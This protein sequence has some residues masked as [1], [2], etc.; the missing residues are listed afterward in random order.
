MTPISPEHLKL[1]GSGPIVLI[2]KIIIALESDDDVKSIV[3]EMNGV[4]ALKTFELLL[5]STFGEPPV[6]MGDFGEDLQAMTKRIFLRASID[7]LKKDDASPGWLFER[8]H[9]MVAK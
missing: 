3:Q 5:S 4:A 9:S 6:E 8:V 1:M 7:I 2:R